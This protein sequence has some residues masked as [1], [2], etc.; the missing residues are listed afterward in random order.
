MTD[1]CFAEILAKTYQHTVTALRPVLEGEWTTV[2]QAEPCALSR[3]AQVASPSPPDVSAPLP[4][5]QYRYSLFTRPGVFFQLG[6]R[7]EISDGRRCY[8]GRASDSF[9][10][11]SHTI[12]VVEIREVTEDERTGLT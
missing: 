3:S 12:T 10:Y 7:L 11:P 2:C 9:S 4:E 6:D 5:S 8:K 1:N